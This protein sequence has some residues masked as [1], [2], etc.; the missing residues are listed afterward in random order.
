MGFVLE[1]IKNVLELHIGGGLHKFVN[2]CKTDHN[3]LCF[4]RCIIWYVIY[5]LVNFSVKNLGYTREQ[6]KHRL[7]GE[8]AREIHFHRLTKYLTYIN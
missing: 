2:I 5:I 4:K 3:V 1:V 6:H 7:K 8:L